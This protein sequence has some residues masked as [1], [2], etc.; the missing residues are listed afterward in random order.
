MTARP[1][2]GPILGGLAEHGWPAPVRLDAESVDA[3]AR[4][5]VELLAGGQGS[6]RL[7]DA[8]AVAE[9]LGVS[10][11]WVYDHAGELGAVRLGEGARPRLRFD[12]DRA[13][14]AWAA[15]SG[16][17]GSQ[18]SDAQRSRGRARR[19]GS[20]VRR[21]ARSGVELLPIRGEEGVGRRAA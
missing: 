1:D 16:S 14:A 21:G 18:A 12:R 19:G 11:A 6:G 3:V 8:Q 4:R 15:R 17:E 7:V 10:R 20:A 9:L 2:R 13:L 5:V